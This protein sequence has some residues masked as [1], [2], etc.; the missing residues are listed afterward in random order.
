MRPATLAPVS[1]D[2][3][4][5]I[6]SPSTTRIGVRATSSPMAAPSRST[7]TRS[8][9]ATRVCFPPVFTTAYIGGRLYRSPTGVHQQVR[10]VGLVHTS[11]TK[12]VGR[13]VGAEEVDVEQEAAALALLAQVGERL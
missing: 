2:G 1:S 7:W 13:S 4:D 5:R 8:P 12:R 6:V 10:T 11:R 3:V 9:S